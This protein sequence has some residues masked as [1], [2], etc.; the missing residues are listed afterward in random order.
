MA[1]RKKRRKARYTSKLGS[2]PVSA[3]MRSDV[4]TI[5]EKTGKTY[6]DIIRKGLRY[7]IHVYKKKV[8]ASS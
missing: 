1:E 6:D 4:E 5:S 2:I 8:A 3:E 7:V